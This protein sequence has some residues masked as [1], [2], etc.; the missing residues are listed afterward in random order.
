VKQYTLQ[1]I[2]IFLFVLFTITPLFS[3]SKKAFIFLEKGENELAK[4]AFEKDLKHPVLGVAARFGLSHL[5]RKDEDASLDDLFKA[6]AMLGE[7]N[8]MIKKIPY[9]KRKKLDNL[10]V[11]SSR[12]DTLTK[13]V[14]R[15]NI[16]ELVRNGSVTALDT[17]MARIPQVHPTLKK[18]LRLQRKKIVENGI[19][20]ADYDELKSLLKNH[21]EFVT[22]NNLQFSREMEERL[23]STFID[24]YGYKELDRFAKAH[25]NHSASMDCYIPQLVEALKAKDILA[26]FNFW[27]KYPLSTLGSRVLQD[28]SYRQKSSLSVLSDTQ[29]VIVNEINWLYEANYQ[30][31]SRDKIPDFADFTKRVQKNIKIHAP[32]IYA[33]SFLGEYLQ[34]CLINQHWEEAIQVIESSQIYFPDV[35]PLDCKT[36]FSYYSEKQDW[37]NG[38][39]P[40][41]KE[42]A[43]GIQSEPIK[44]INT[45]YGNELSPVFS[46]DGQ[47]LYFAG[48]NRSD[49]YEEEDVFR[50]IWDG[51]IWSEPTLVPNLSGE[52][53]QAPLSLTADAT[54]MLVFENGKLCI[55]ERRD[56]GWTKPQSLGGT[57][58]SFPWVGKAV[59]ASNGKAILMEAS[60]NPKEMMSP[61]NIDLYVSVRGNDGVWQKPIS[62]G[63]VINTDNQERSPYLHPDG[64]TLYFSSNGHIGLGG[65]D[66]FVARR[67]GEG[68]TTWEK[69][70]NLGKEINDTR[71]NWGFS[72]VSLDGR[73]GFFSSDFEWGAGADL[74]RIGMPMKAAP[75]LVAAIS[76]KV[77]DQS[78]EAI[79]DGFMVIDLD[80]TGKNTLRI[81]VR[82]DGTYTF[83][84]P[85]G[86][87]PRIHLE[88]EGQLAEWKTI[89]LTTVAR[90]T[91]IKDSVQTISIKKMEEGEASFPLRSVV[92]AYNSTELPTE[93]FGELKT[94]AEVAKKRNWKLTFVGHTDNVG[95]DAANMTISN[96]RAS[97]VRAYMTDNLGYASSLISVEGKGAIQPKCSNDTESGRLCNRRVEVRVEK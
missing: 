63:N 45:K 22:K 18:E 36:N 17:F 13:A 46:V 93:S 35:R 19:H 89:D 68:W 83:V 9:K 52:G 15:L 79:K 55:S 23:F 29:K 26:D 87:K 73:A 48:S 21:N 92:F 41:L 85:L 75:D 12:L 39:I 86:T 50:S 88:K 60:S 16:K 81:P 91:V 24:K 53:N 32:R 62:L 6:A 56:T 54:R 58:N 38:V 80:S 27:E 14:H 37:F 59:L 78:G 84:A 95:S 2:S 8:A 77:Q 82:P 33:Y 72:G 10:K 47:E 57:I 65:L 5:I 49:N 51:N 34:H 76:G 43:Q 97:A 42:A 11:T 69:P 64:R 30:L 61:S 3:Q 74:W 71:E 96:Q 94:L 70:V 66:I 25:P 7:A 40:I 1:H 20:N 44:E 90:P 67:I 31:R 28:I 4:L